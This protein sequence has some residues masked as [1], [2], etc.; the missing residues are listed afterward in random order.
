MRRLFR[1][2]LAFLLVVAIVAAAVFFADRPGTVSVSWLGWHAD[3]AL[4]IAAVA[5]LAA[6]L[7][8]WVILSIT[9]IG[10]AHV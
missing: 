10:R 7:I 8:L 3:V 1:G 2:L 6:V 4:G 5:L 9:E